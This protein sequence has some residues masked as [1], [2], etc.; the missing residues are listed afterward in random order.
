MASPIIPRSYDEWRHCITILCGIPL[1]P[2]YVE[3][4][5]T[6]LADPADHGTQRFVQTWGPAHLEAVRA[7][8]AQARSELAAGATL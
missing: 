5:L 3:T 1:T 8:F 2:T 4:R 7:W 6:A